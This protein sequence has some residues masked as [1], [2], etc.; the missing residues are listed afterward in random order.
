MKKVVPDLSVPG[1]GLTL[2]DADAERF[3]V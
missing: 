2:R 1:H 3:A